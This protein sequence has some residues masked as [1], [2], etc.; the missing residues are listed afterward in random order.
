[1]YELRY[2]L[3]SINILLMAVKFDLQHAQ[4]SDGINLT[5]LSVLPDPEN[6]DNGF[7]ISL[8]SLVHAKLNVI[9]YILPVD[10]RRR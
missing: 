6:M 1:M 4:T 7:G 3:F 8:R 9:C 2:T 5:S 10:G